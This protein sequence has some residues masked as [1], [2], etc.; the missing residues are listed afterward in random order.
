MN[1]DILWQ[2][3]VDTGDPSYY[4]LYKSASDKER[5]EKR[6]KEGGEGRMP[7]ATD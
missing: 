2:A 7:A 1:S 3:F 4:V 6:K 5:E